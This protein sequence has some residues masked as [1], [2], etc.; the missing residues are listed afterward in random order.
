M[1]GRFCRNWC[2]NENTGF[3]QCSRDSGQQRS[4]N[5]L[6]KSPYLNCTAGQKLT[7]IMPLRTHGC[8][9]R[10]AQLAHRT[11]PDS[12]FPVLHSLLGKF[13][14]YRGTV[15][16]NNRIPWTI[17]ELASPDAQNPPTCTEQRVNGNSVLLD[18]ILS[19]YSFTSFLLVINKR[20]LSFK[21]ANF[22]LLYSYCQKS[23]FR[24][25]LPFARS[26]RWLC[27]TFLR[28]RQ[29][30]VLCQSPKRG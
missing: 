17:L 22:L 4:R 27:R 23:L 21:M 25:C 13:S 6:A 29:V 5:L 24:P 7:K 18:Q 14:V 11:R 19:Y 20:N 2:P 1:W 30:T 16:R 12:K 26:Y 10:T 3:N 9:A 8:S 15:W 28:A